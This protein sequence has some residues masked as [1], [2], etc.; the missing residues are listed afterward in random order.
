MAIKEIN[1]S[2]NPCH[3]CL[4]VIAA[5]RRRIPIFHFE[6]GNRCYDMRVPEEI[7]RRIVDHTSDVNLT[8][9]TIARESLLRE[10]LPPD[11]VVNV[12]SPMAE[13]LHHYDAKY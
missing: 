9:S 13:V 2:Q 12:G 8:Y 10:G 11:L 4:A 7:N 5:K 3:S 6:A 1:N